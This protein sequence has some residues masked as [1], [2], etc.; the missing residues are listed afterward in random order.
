MSVCASAPYTY[1][2]AGRMIR[3]PFSWGMVSLA[4]VSE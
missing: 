3:R 1:F 4:C 2:G